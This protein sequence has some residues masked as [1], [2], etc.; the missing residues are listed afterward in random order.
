MLITLTLP[1]PRHSLCLVVLVNCLPLDMGSSKGNILSLN[2]IFHV[3]LSQSF[4]YTTGVL[5]KPQRM[6]P[7]LTVSPDGQWRRFISRISFCLPFLYLSLRK[8][9]S[10]PSYLI[11][12]SLPC[13][14]TLLSLRVIFVT[15]QFLCIKTNLSTVNYSEHWRNT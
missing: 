3:S 13:L 11:F 6:R 15:T 7:S 5:S 14:Y 8:P 12:A 9:C 1:Q 10:F 4:L 2:L